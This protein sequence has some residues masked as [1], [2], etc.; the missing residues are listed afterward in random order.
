MN[1][2]QQ[3][4]T[5]FYAVLFGAMLT[6]IGGLRAFPWGFPAEKDGKGRLI[7]RLIISIICFNIIPFLL[8]SAGYSVLDNTS[9]NSVSFW[10]VVIIAI[11]SLSVYAPY[12]LYHLFMVLFNGT[13]LE[14]YPVQEYEEII[15][16]RTIRESKLGHTLAFIF[17]IGIFMLFYYAR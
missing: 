16:K 8:F 13:M 4:F 11:A 10:Q 17:Y 15:G 9:V 12:R 14:L 6:S 3:I 2:T 7:W 5:I 1:E